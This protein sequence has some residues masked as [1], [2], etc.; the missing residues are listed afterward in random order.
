MRE[1]S[2]PLPT[3][4]GTENGASETANLLSSG[5]VQPLC[6]VMMYCKRDTNNLI[7]QID[8]MCLSLPLQLLLCA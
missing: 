4:D 1:L 5:N 3:F 6:L 2:S 7:Y 8:K